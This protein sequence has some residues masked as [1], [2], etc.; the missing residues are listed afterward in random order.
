[1]KKKKV[2]YTD[3]PMHLKVVPDFLPSPDQLVLKEETIKVTLELSRKSVEFFK[4]QAEATQ[5]AYQPM[6]RALIDRYAAH[7]TAPSP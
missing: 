2:N 1:M 7:Y 6:I 5:S 3:E 4:Q